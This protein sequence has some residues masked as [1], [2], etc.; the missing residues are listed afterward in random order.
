[1]DD[2]PQLSFPSLL[3]RQSRHLDRLPVS[4]WGVHEKSGDADLLLFEAEAGQQLVFDIAAQRFG[5]KAGILLTLS[6]AQGK[7]LASSSRFDSSN[8][9]L[10]AYTFPRAG[11]YS[12][13][14][15]S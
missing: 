15:S 10:L 4:V 7:V 12:L 5:S 11:Q 13:R 9:P 2:L 14:V 8:D 1:M 3:P 6:D